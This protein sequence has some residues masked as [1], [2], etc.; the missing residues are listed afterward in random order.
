MKKS[1]KKNCCNVKD[2]ENYIKYFCRIFLYFSIFTLFYCILDNIFVYLEDLNILF[3]NFFRVG[4][5]HCSFCSSLILWDPIPY[6]SKVI[7]KFEASKSHSRT[8]GLYM[9]KF[10]MGYLLILCGQFLQNPYEVVGVY[11]CSY[12][13]WVFP[14]S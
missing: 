3:H 2:C 7:K 4:V 10:W 6:K 1:I 9:I 14:I 11:N 13:R 5:W 12:K 8:H